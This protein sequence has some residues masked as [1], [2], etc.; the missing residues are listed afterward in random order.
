M[1]HG[2]GKMSVAVQQAEVVHIVASLQHCN[3]M[4][5]G[6]RESHSE[7]LS[8]RCCAEGHLLQ[9]FRKGKGISFWR[10]AL[11]WQLWYSGDEPRPVQCSQATETLPSQYR[12]G[13]RHAS[14][15]QKQCA[16]NQWVYG[17]FKA[18]LLLCLH[19]CA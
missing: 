16:R 6:L 10:S 15:C 8:V 12:P 2:G 11:M 14:S 7:N 3:V 13:K 9:L 5:M 4:A 1:W 18:R 17:S 19:T